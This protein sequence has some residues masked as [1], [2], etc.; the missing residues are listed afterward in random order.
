MYHVQCLQVL[1]G[2]SLRVGAGERVA[3]VGPSGSGKSTVLKLT[4]RLY[5]PITGCVRVEGVDV[6]QLTK[7]SLRA[8]MAV[9]P[10]DTVLFNDSIMENIR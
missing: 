6:R 1:N 5:D 3:I 7:A 4:A 8:T 10:Q 9:V 2:L